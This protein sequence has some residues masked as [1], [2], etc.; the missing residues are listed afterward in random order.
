MSQSGLGGQS[1]VG[2]KGGYDD[3]DSEDE[4]REIDE[5]DPNYDYYMK[6]KK[7]FS[8]SKTGKTIYKTDYCE[9]NKRKKRNPHAQDV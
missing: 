5:N 8:N 2:K 7:I 4:V 1:G 6:M 3:E 9:L